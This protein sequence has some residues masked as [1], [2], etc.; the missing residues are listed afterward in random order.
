LVILASIDG[1]RDEV[2]FAMRS[3]DKSKLTG[4]SPSA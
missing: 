2:R 3:R 4:A 1:D